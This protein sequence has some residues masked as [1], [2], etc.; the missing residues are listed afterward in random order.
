MTMGHLAI[1]AGLD[2]RITK[3]FITFYEFVLRKKEYNMKTFE[4]GR[5]SSGGK[6]IFLLLS[7]P[8]G[9]ITFFITFTGFSL[10]IVTLIV[11]LGIPVLFATFTMIRSMALLERKLIAKYLGLIPPAARQQAASLTWFQRLTSDLR[12]ST[13]WKYALYMC[14]KWPLGFLSFSLTLLCLAAS[15][16]MT[17]LPIIYIIITW[18]F[19]V[20]EL[21][22]GL[23]S[24]SGWSFMGPG[25][26]SFIEITGSFD[27]MMFGRSFSGLVICLALWPLT[28]MVI[29]GL[30]GIWKRL[31]QALLFA[32]TMQQYEKP[33]PS[34]SHAHTM[35]YNNWST[36]YGPQQ[37]RDHDSPAPPI[38]QNNDMPQAHY[39][40]MLQ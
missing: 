16:C 11:W 37:R 23:E 13:I 40:Q 15:I 1:Y 26:Q 30:V 18:I 21:A 29:N 39:P 3:K 17:L 19:A 5:A 6:I 20:P 33:G 12:D 36:G 14:I 7:L 4:S 38:A 34:S 32:S 25:S 27:W 28:F 10:G 22:A 8:V 31:A 35:E 9:I 2:I 24:A